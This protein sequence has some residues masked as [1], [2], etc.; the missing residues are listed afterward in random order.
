MHSGRICILKDNLS[1]TNNR[2]IMA[3]YVVLSLTFEAQMWSLTKSL[4]SPI[5]GTSEGKGLTTVLSL[6]RKYYYGNREWSFCLDMGCC[7]GGG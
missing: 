4:T 3:Q 2:K 1:I 5:R 6:I 7:G